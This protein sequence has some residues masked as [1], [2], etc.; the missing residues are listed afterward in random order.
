MTRML[1]VLGIKRDWRM[2]PKARPNGAGAT[3]GE[4][5][6]PTIHGRRPCGRGPQY[7]N[8]PV[9]EVTEG[10]DTRGAG[11]RD[12]PV[13][14]NMYRG[15]RPRFRRGPS[16]QRQP[17]EDSNEEDKENQ[18]DE[19]RG[20]QRPQRQYRRHF[21]N[22][23]RCPECPKPQGDKE[24]KAADP[25]AE[26]SSPPPPTHT[27]TYTNPRLSRAGPS[28]SRL[29]ISTIILFGHPTGRTEYE[30]PAI[31]N[32]LKIGAKALSACFFVC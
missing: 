4:G 5:S 12:R 14:Q 17:R 8:P 23:R 19:T 25:P 7:S 24:T 10:A 32:E 15:Y 2:L 13:K 21:S 28:K 31:R 30:I 27:H 6:H 1:R 9:Q 11:E 20:Q 18:G 26:N 16:H 3:A 29:T 22:R